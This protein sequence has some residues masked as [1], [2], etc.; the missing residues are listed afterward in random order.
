[1]ARW[2]NVD[3]ELLSSIINPR[4]YTSWVS[5]HLYFDDTPLSFLVDRIEKTNGVEVAV[6]D[7]GLLNQKLSGAVDFY[8]LDELAG[9]I[10]EV[11]DI[12]LHHSDDQ[13]CLSRYTRTY[14]NINIKN[15]NMNID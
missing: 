12:Q 15:R 3:S 14:R 4:S 6:V 10:S 7:P 9:A 8:G 13:V 11:L 1:M 5:D 2:S